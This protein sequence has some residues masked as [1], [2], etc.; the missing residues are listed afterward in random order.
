MPSIWRLCFLPA[1]AV[2]LAACPPAR[3]Q[4]SPEARCFD[5]CNA[6]ASSPCNEHDCERGCRFVLDRLVEREDHNVVTCVASAKT[7]GDDTWANCAV[8]VGIHVDGG[9]PVPPPLKDDQDESE[10]AEKGD[11]LE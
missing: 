8:R 1:I 3:P 6:R 7:C 2:A 9:P 5:D 11:L 4:G 10:G